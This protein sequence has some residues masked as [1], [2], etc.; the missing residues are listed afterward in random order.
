MT[1]ITT[2]RPS[3]VEIPTV[4][5]VQ[6]PKSI[7]VHIWG[8]I[9]KWPVF[10]LLVLFL[11]VFA[12]IFAPLLSPH[13]P[14]KQT[15]RDRNAPPAWFDEGSTKYLL[16]ADRTGRDLL[17]RIIYGARVSLTVAG[18]SL[19]S[20][21]LAGVTLGLISGWYGGMTDEVISRIVDIWYAV[22]FL[23]VALVVVVTVGQS[24]TV[25]F[26]VLALVSWVAFVRNVRA[27]VLSIKQ[28]EY[29]LMA[30]IYG[31]STRHIM[32]RHLLPGVF[33]TIIVI[34]TL[35]VGSLILTESTLSFLGAGI[36]QPTPSWGVMVSDGREYLADAWWVS[37]FPGTA[38]F[39]TV[40]SLNFLGDWLRDF[41]DP[42]L[43][44]QA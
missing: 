8:F 20:G 43:R 25:M 4:R 15:L 18:V 32:I 36:P 23:L 14:I 39:L 26:G 21:L 6:Q 2:G 41:F 13:D 29:V 28:R 27:E 24:L 34:A 11:L 37:V 35:S 38:I 10:P 12:A 33:P 1:E 17:S 7:Q 40:L 22:P 19:A 16:G 30:R 5:P 9:R 42:R 3:P 44:Q 31:A